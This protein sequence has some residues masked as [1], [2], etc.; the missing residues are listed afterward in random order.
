[1]MRTSFTS[2]RTTEYTTGNQGRNFN[3]AAPELASRDTSSES[4]EELQDSDRSCI[5]RNDKG[6]VPPE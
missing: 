6:D 5:Y 3:T 4:D 1:M 2:I